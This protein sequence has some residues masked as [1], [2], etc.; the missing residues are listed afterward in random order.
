MLLSAAERL[1]D[2]LISAAGFPNRELKVFG[3]HRAASPCA[4]RAQAAGKN[5]VVWNPESLIYSTAAAE[6]A[7]HYIN[8]RTN[9]GSDNFTHD[10]LPRRIITSPVY[11]IQPWPQIILAN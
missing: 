2:C 10:W 11:F 7:A 3:G 5:N 4:D 9:P 8:N 6:S 1:Q